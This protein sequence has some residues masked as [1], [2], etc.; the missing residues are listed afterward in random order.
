MS[1][2]GLD[3]SSPYNKSNPHNK[4]TAYNR[5]HGSYPVIADPVFSNVIARLKN[6]YGAFFRLN[7]QFPLEHEDSIPKPRNNS[8]NHYHW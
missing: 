2:P 6:R 1:R 4:S 7:H 5:F 8:E 3:K